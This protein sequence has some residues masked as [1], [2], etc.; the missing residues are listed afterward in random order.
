M[1][2]IEPH[3]DDVL[4][5]T[6][7]LKLGRI[8]A[9]GIMRTLQVGERATPLAL[10]L[11]EIGRIDK[12][13]HTLNFIDDENRRRNTLVQLNLGEGR[14]A[15]AR[16]I[17]HGK[18]GE[19][20]QRYREGQEDQLSALGLVLNV[21]VLWN[22]LYMDAV[23]TQLR[24]EGYPVLDEDVARLSPFAHPH[25]NMLGRY[26]FEVHDSVARGELRT[27]RNPPEVP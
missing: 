3:W 11:A 8:P 16:N 24:K 20:Y 12:T 2:L 21:V 23:L 18:R 6:G 25:I 26:S 5:L 27:L 22:T 19:L 15:L 14:H 4:R 17:F 1:S 13:I 10:A 7:S 9:I